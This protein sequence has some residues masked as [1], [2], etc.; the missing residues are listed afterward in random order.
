MRLKIIPLAATG[1]SPFFDPSSPWE[2]YEESTSDF[3]ARLAALEAGAQ[4]RPAYRTVADE[5]IHI[6]RHLGREPWPVDNCT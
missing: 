4:V 2:G 1:N 6:K 3:E 5:I